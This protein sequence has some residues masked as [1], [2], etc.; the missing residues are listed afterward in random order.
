[1]LMLKTLLPRWSQHET[2]L[3]LEEMAMNETVEKA[4]AMFSCSIHW[5]FC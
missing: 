3:E 5:T 4:N 1:M 2:R